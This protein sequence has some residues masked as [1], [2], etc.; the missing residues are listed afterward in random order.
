M[1][2]NGGFYPNEVAGLYTLSRRTEVYAMGLSRSPM[3]IRRILFL[4]VEYGI[5]YL[6]L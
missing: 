5:F 1:I 4:I 3:W 2:R 6:L